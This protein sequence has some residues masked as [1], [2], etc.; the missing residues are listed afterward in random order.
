[1]IYSTSLNLKCNKTMKN[2]FNLKIQNYDIL[3]KMFW[4]KNF[5]PL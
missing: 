3:F 5:K 4:E 2:K 1:M